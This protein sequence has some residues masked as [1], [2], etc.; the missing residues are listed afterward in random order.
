MQLSRNNKNKNL[1]NN[2]NTSYQNA[3]RA[4]LEQVKKKKLSRSGLFY[5]IDWRPVGTKNKTTKQNK[6]I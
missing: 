2:E 1:K 6:I 3:W 4:H 5:W